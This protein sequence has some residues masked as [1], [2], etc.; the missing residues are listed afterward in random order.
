MRF[1]ARA[2]MTVL[3]LAACTTG[4]TQVQG[5]NGTSAT[6]PT[7]ATGPTST[8]P[9]GATG[10]TAA[11]GGP[12]SVEFPPDVAAVS[13]RAFF[14]CDGLEGTW[15]Y[16]FGADFG[17]GI[18]MDIETTVDMEGGDG[19]LVI[20]ESFEVPGLGTVAFTD[21]IELVVAGTPEAP[22]LQAT[23]ITV[24]VEGNIPGL[25]E[26]AEAFF[27]ENAEVPVVAGAEQ[28]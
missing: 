20:G 11:A 13:E 12:F 17:G 16:V 19:T 7:A 18:A 5:G 6:G 1:L 28:C 21:T 9:T 22:T 2:L 15:T 23:S 25:E 14:T 10:S 27:T 3:L 24:D 8:G 4:E 26:I